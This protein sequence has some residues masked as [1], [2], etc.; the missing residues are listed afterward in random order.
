MIGERLKKIRKE[1]KIKQEELAA[2]LGVT[3]ATISLYETNKNFPS[4]K[5]K[6]GIARYFNL[7]LDYLMGIIDEPVPYYREERF[8][9]LPED[10]TAGER[11]YIEDSI[12]FVKYRKS[13]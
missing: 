7:S 4:D 5:I 12:A 3:N 10:F 8:I 6:I 13:Q 2:V 11:K 9:M 1:K